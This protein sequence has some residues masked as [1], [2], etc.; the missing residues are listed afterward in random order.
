MT[1]IMWL[2]ESGDHVGVDLICLLAFCFLSQLFFFFL[3]NII[4]K[5]TF[6]FLSHI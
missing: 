5:L 4:N 6:I 2:P 3:I 1:K